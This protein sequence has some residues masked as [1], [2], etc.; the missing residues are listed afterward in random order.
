MFTGAL[1]IF[2]RPVSVYTECSCRKTFFKL[3]HRFCLRWPRA[4]GI[5]T[6]FYIILKCRT[7]HDTLI[8]TAER[9]G[10]HISKKRQRT[11][12]GIFVKLFHLC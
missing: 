10:K 7:C 2:L 9:K 11:T 12:V 1:F 8:S 3:P 5:I 4:S 6:H